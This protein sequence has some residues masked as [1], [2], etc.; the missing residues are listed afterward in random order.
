MAADIQSDMINVQKVT[1][2]LQVACAALGIP[3]AAS[4]TYSVY[5][6]Y[7]STAATCQTLKTSLLAT[8]DRALPADSIRTLMKKDLETFTAQCAASDPDAIAAFAT[9]SQQADATLVTKDRRPVNGQTAPVGTKY[10]AVRP[11]STQR[12]PAGAFAAI[13]VGVFGVNSAGEA[14]GWVA[15]DRRD[16]DHFG[17]TSFDGYEVGKPL[18]EATILRTR[19]A[20]P[21]WHEAQPPG[22]PDLSHVQGRLAAGQC[23]RVLTVPLKTGPR[24]WAGVELAPCGTEF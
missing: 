7:F 20:V 23:V 17:E 19:W 21:V 4:G 14:K 16:P 6:A 2:I 15:L 12:A 9:V 8:M 18:A 1:S 10:D 11:V 3:A 5:R 13:P 24:P 22:P